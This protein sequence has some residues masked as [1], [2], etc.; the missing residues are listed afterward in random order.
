MM[1]E[2]NMALHFSVLASGS[3][4]NSSFVEADGFGVLL[5]AGLGP[6][7]LAARLTA[8]DR[9]WANIHAVLLTH[10]HGD[11]WNERTLAHLRRL[12]VPFYCHA[13]HH[14]SLSQ[15]SSAFVEMRAAQLVR[16]YELA[17]RFSL[18]PTLSC[19]PLALSHDEM[20]CGF[21]FEASPGPR[22]EPSTLGYAADLGSWQPTLVD[23]L[24]NV[25]ILAL[26]FN[27]DVFLEKS[28]R[29]SPNLILRVLG[30]HGHLSNVQA[31][32]LFREVLQ[33][34]QPG[35][36]Q[37]LVQL[38]LSRQCNRP[39][40]AVDAARVVLEE[41]KADVAIHT[42]KQESAGPSL[43]VGERSCG[44]TRRPS[45]RAPRKKLAE[46]LRYFQPMLPGWE[47]E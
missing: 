22:D 36:P 20:T 1:E 43:K 18:S 8:V 5:D 21:R 41:L 26:E 34:S 29:R 24:A 45:R 9:G 17:K 47:G 2:K 10:T 23:A 40:M 33:R 38:H 13:D 15:T 3:S 46:P 35:R 19:T 12:R 42:S 27:H 44:A 31:A 25:D 14:L 37:H 30:D 16:G 4:G 6:R 28:S 11:H 32:E 7:L 39:A